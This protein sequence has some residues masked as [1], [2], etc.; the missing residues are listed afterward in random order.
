MHFNSSVGRNC[1]VTIT[2]IRGDVVLQRAIE[3]PLQ[4]NGIATC[5]ISA[6]AS[7]HYFVHVTAGE[8]VD[9]VAVDVVR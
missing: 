5:D 6:L 8:Y 9:T 1:N 4:S 2:D 3:N 7:G